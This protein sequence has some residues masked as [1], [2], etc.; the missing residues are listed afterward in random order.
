[1]YLSMG[2][3]IR[4]LSLPPRPTA[5]DRIE[6]SLLYHSNMVYGIGTD[7]H[8]EKPFTLVKSYERVFI[9]AATLY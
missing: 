4:F 7:N 3:H 5:P 2:V 8:F 6:Q 1:M 9:H